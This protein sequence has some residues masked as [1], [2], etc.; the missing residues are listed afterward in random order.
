MG[1]NKDL[2]VTVSAQERMMRC[3]RCNDDGAVSV[4]GYCRWCQQDYLAARLRFAGS[5]PDNKLWELW[6]KR[7]REG[8][9]APSSVTAVPTS[10]PRR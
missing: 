7:Y 4:E 2:T 8:D 10:K 5:M 3:S 9:H 1:R 6:D